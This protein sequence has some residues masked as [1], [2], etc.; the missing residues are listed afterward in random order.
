MYGMKGMFMGKRMRGFGSPMFYGEPQHEFPYPP[1]SELE[2]LK[3]YKD[4]LELR[5]KEIESE[6]KAVEKRISELNEQQ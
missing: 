4:R 3:R 1:V 2:A 6:L 5:R